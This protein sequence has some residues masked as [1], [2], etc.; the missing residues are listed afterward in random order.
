MTCCNHNCEQGK[1]CPERKQMDEKN[2]YFV[3]GAI[4]GTVATAL[5]AIGA[6]KLYSQ[7]PME[8]ILPQSIVEAYNMGLKDAL[9]TNPVSP[10]LDEVC[11]NLWAGRQ[12]YDRPRR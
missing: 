3:R 9:R 6:N 11:L 4:V 5:I 8:N 12:P 7:R 10:Q 1:R 2:G